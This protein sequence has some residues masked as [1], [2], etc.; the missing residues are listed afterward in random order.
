MFVRTRDSHPVGATLVLRIHGIGDDIRAEC[1]VRDVHPN[2]FGAE[3]TN[4]IPA[5]ERKLKSL[6]LSLKP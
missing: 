1:V 4:L 3:F 5:E 2:G 6:L